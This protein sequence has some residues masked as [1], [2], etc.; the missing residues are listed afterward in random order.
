MLY[1]LYETFHINLLHYITV[2][3]TI[4]FFVGVHIGHRFLL[5]QL[6]KEAAKQKQKSL[7]ISFDTHPKN[8][9]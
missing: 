5:D 2:R 9:L 1:W 7:V 6:K 4:G 3:A 8:I